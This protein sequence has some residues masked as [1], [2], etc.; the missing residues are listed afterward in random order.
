[1]ITNKEVFAKRRE[2]ALDE[3]YQ[4]ALE[5]MQGPQISD[6]DIKAFAWCLIDL[7]KRDVQVDNSQDFEHYRLQLEAIKID[8]NDD[9]LPKNIRYVLSLYNPHRKLITQAMELSKKGQHQNAVNL[10]R[11]VWLSGSADRDIQTELGWELYKLSK[12]LMNVANPDVGAVKRNLNNYLKLDVEK[13]SLLHSCFLQLASKL[14]GDGF[15][16]LVFSHLWN[17]DYLRP[18]D[19]ERNHGDDDKE[20]PSLAEKVIQQAS[21]ESVKS[22][23]TQNLN[24]ILPHINKA[25]DRFH[26]NI[27]LKLN[28]AKVLLALGRNDDA[29]AFGLEVAKSKMNDYWSWELLGDICAANDPDAALGCFCKALLSSNDDKFTGKVRLKLAERMVKAGEYAA[30]RLE[31]ERVISYRERESQ[32]IPDIASRLA[33]QP[34]YQETLASPSNMAYYR[35]MALVAESLLFS[36]LPWISACVGE[37]FMIPGKEGKPKPK[38]KLYVKTSAFPMEVSIPESKGDFRR[39]AI[40]DAI[41]LKGEQ[42][43]NG[44][45]QVYVIEARREGVTWDIF[46]EKIGVIDH[47]NKQKN[48]IHFIVDRKIEGVIPLSE[49]TTSFKEGEAV[50]LKLAK[51]ITNKGERYRVLQAQPSTAIPDSSIRKEF[52]EEVRE[53]REMGF[54]NNDIFVPPFLMNLEHIRDGDLISGVAIINYNKKRSS[55]GWKAIS[56]KKIVQD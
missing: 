23:N 53:E 43:T 39:L 20:Y 5:L 49:L 17:L 21:K 29:L 54:T 46:P 4:M 37:K 25:I 40:G 56:I 9:V 35:S 10:Y 1:M 8:P 26:D 32:R 34:W 38:R 52:H 11:E 2:G 31:V 47:V 16:M 33:S 15:N 22:D 50:A 13:P 28:K 19:F 45:F 55:W 18:E 12:T 41:M 14:S 36:R 24:Y 48:L 51:Y 6:W 30:A 27:W 42:D 44:R 7:I 3:A